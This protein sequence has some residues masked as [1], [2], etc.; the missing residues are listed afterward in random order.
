MYR[1]ICIEQKHTHSWIAEKKI[2]IYLK[3]ESKMFKNNFENNKIH[4]IKL[5]N[6]VYC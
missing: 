5:T 4:S 3:A 1:T 2:A 6:L